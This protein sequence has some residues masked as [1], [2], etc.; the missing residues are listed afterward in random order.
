MYPVM[1]RSATSPCRS[2]SSPSG[3][4]GLGVERERG[5]HPGRRREHVRADDE[6]RDAGALVRVLDEVVG[7]GQVR[8]AGRPVDERLDQPQLDQHLGPLVRRR[9]FLQ[10]APQQQR[11]RS[12][13]LRGPSPSAPRR[14]APRPSPRSPRRGA[15]RRWAATA[16][17]AAPC[18]CSRRA[19]RSWCSAR[20][21]AGRSPYTASRTSGWTNA[22]G[23]GPCRISPRLSVSSAAAASSSG[24]RASA[25]TVGSPASSPE[26]GDRARH[27]RDRR[28]ASGAA[29]ASPG[30]TRRASPPRAR[31]RRG[32]RRDARPRPPA[33]AAAG[34][35]AAGCRTSSGGRRRRRTSAPSPRRSRTSVSGRLGDSGRGRSTVTDGSRAIS[36]SSA[37][38]GC[39]S[40]VRTRHDDQHRQALE[41]LDEVGEEAERGA[42]APLDVVDADH[43]AARRRRG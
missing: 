28:S 39:C 26:H 8:G 6:H 30:T 18:S 40:P 19:A 43:A 35:A 12:P 9:R 32:T 36:A 13:R 3:S 1:R 11:P 5:R 42:V 14:G 29:A 24:S 37:S 16:S 21:A 10:R 22:S 7:L 27:G 17:A 38:S 23:A 4:V 41:P 25:A 33:R 20:S 15:S 34:A 2:S 31:C